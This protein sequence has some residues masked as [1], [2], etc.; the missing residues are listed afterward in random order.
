MF[1]DHVSIGITDFKKSAKF[2][3]LVLGAMGYKRNLTYEGEAIC[4]GEQCE[5]WIGVEKSVTRSNGS[6]I[7][8]KAKCKEDIHKFYDEAI[9]NGGTC[10]GKPGPR[11]EYNET[12]YAAYVLDPDGNKI[13]ACIY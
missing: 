1:I 5:L 10:D 4:Y 12:Y 9:K 7:A 6:H 2:Y 13:E 8:F 3:D 11:P